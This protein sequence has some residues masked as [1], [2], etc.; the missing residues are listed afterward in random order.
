M[1]NPEI[2]NQAAEQLTALSRKTHKTVNEVVRWLLDNYAYTLTSPEEQT[3]DNDM[4]WTEAELSEF[5]Q[6]QHPLTRQQIAEQGLPGGWKDAGIVDSMEW[7]E[8]QRAKR[9]N[10]T[11]W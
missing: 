5:L 6:P 3:A 7:L 11:R 8:Q 2:S 9:R 10:K 4:V 1:S